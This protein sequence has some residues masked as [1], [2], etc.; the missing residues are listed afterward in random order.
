MMLNKIIDA[1]QKRGDLAG[2]TVRHLQTREAQVYAVPSGIE[3]QRTVENERFLID[4]LKNNSM[5]DGSPAIG[6]GNAS[7]LP[8]DDIGRAID[9]AT[10]V[11]GLVANPVYGLPG[12]SAIPDVPI[13][14]ESLRKA[15]TAVMMDVMERLQGEAGNYPGVRMTAA[16]C[17][18]EVR[19]THLVNSRGLDVE[20]DDTHVA[21][22]FVLHSRKG[23]HESE[24][25]DEVTYRR[26]AD[27]DLESVLAS[28]AQHSLDSLEADVPTSWQGPIVLRNDALAVFMGG[29]DLGG[30]VIQNLSSAGSK[31]SKFTPW[32]VGTSVFKGEVKGDPLTIWANR[33]LPYGKASD[34]FDGE[35][36]PAQRLELIRDGVLVNFSAS[37]RYA[38]YLNIPA[39][40]AFGNVE[41]APGKTPAS[42]L[43][44]EPHIEIIQFSW[45]NPDAIT[46]DFATEIR[47]GYIVENGRRK[48]FKGGMLV[49]NYLEALADVRWSADTK[50]FGS[51]MGPHTAR[52]NGMKID[53]PA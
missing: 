42:A 13:C 52:F 12:P 10:L 38:D 6:N 32:E 18:G 43:I 48:P 26:V 27:L 50:F 1:L 5:P 46:G 3:S 44:A 23:D 22:E 7:L 2:W 49:G 20:Q 29:S 25:F 9:Q 39:T 30:N 8:G 31:Y 28:R 37:Q 21:V 19:H 33:A 24:T 16:E 41:L 35:G 45:F 36:L 53:G 14:D 11:A 15:P 17:F 4:V 34:R 47:F 51:Y 40:G